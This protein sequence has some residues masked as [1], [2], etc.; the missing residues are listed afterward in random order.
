MKI[1]I[2]ILFHILFIQS[3]CAQGGNKLQMTVLNLAES[4]SRQ[5]EVP[6]SQFVDKI[7]YIPL[8]TNP[9]ALI[10]EVSYYEVTDEFVI[11]KTSARG[12]QHILLFDRNT[13]KFIREIGKQGRGPGEFLI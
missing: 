9:E 5:K 10:P 11:V 7:S 3:L 4:F 13:G 12:I 8:E 2:S 1:F 6:L